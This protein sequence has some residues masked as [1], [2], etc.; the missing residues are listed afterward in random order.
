MGHEMQTDVT[1]DDNRFIAVQEVFDQTVSLFHLLTALAEQIHGRGEMSAGL[2]GVLRGLDRFGP[3]TV[4]QMAR[5]RQV[6]RQHIQTEVNQLEAER[7]VELVDNIAHRRSRLV[8][9]TPEGEAY[10]HA[11]YQREMAF[12]AALKLPIPEDALHT[13]AAVLQAV[14]DALEHAQLRLT[15][16]G[17][18]TSKTAASSTAGDERI[19]PDTDTVRK[20]PNI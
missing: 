11:M 6:S 5:A 18:S 4:P 13:T 9:L 8:R 16:E 3:Q 1:S 17:E 15:R 10:L 20:E 14:Y 7:L 12:F 2:R 19:P